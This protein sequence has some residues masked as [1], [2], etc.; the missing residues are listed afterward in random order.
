M[1]PE[2]DFE[3]L[4]ERRRSVEWQ[5]VTYLELHRRA[6]LTELRCRVTWIIARQ[7]CPT[8]LYSWRL[9]EQ[10]AAEVD[11]AVARL[12]AE[13]DIECFSPGNNSLWY[14]RL[15]QEQPCPAI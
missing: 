9:R 5:V 12:Y 6:C 15:R 13:G 8:E 11:S 3:R 1:S 7:R 2:E 4:I 10:F 14:Y